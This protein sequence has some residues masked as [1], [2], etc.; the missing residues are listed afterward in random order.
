MNSDHN[1]HVHNNNNIAHNISQPNQELASPYT[2]S[3]EQ[4]TS[5]YHNKWS[6]STHSRDIPS[7]KWS[8][9]TH[10]KGVGAVHYTYYF[11]DLSKQQVYQSIKVCHTPLYMHLISPHRLPTTGT[12]H[13]F[14]IATISSKSVYIFKMRADHCT[15]TPQYHYDHGT[16]DHTTPPI[17]WSQNMVTI[18]KGHT[19][20]RTQHKN[21]YIKDNFS[22]PQM[23]TFLHLLCVLSLQEEG[24]S[25]LRT[26]IVVP[27]VSFNS[28]FI[29]Y[30]QAIRKVELLRSLPVPW[31]ALLIMVIPV[32]W[33][34]MNV[35]DYLPLGLC[36][37]STATDDDDPL[38]WSSLSTVAPPTEYPDP[39]TTITITTH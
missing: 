10:P 18:D 30:H 6:Q 25:L 4:A 22:S 35:I 17:K 21:L 29:V 20:L 33:N 15:V 14:L 28:G 38:I 13:S 31:D 16:V 23:T 12:D 3:F 37:S 8:N 34:V 27:K 11:N 5:Q 32:W 36:Y 9:S 2:C 39:I 26:K 24:H 7:W 1:T 19:V